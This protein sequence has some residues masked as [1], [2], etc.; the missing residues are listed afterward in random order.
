MRRA[1]ERGCVVR[2]SRAATR[3][4]RD[5]FPRDASITA[6][7]SSAVPSSYVRM[8]VAPRTR[9]VAQQLLRGCSD[10]L[11]GSARQGA[12][13]A[14]LWR[15]VATPALRRP[16]ATATLRRVASTLRRIASTLR[17]VPATG[18]RIASALRG[19]L[20]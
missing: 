8:L 11:V 16:V 17:R 7:D 13:A 1:Y 18:R 20:H 9:H 19:I 4:A 12:A 3:R 6:R 5:A 10:E 15:P 14:A 2:A